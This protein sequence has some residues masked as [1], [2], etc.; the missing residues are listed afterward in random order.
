MKE[1]KDAWWPLGIRVKVKN[2]RLLI[3]SIQEY[4]Q[5]IFYHKI[6]LNNFRMLCHERKNKQ[7]MAIKDE[8]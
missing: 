4:K 8:G 5:T 7:L 6:F 3:V 2:I 1:K